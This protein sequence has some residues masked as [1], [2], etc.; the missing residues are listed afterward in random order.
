MLTVTDEESGNKFLRINV[1]GFEG[2][3]T[4]LNGVLRVTDD[5][6]KLG[7]AG[8]T[9]DAV[10]FELSFKKVKDVALCAGDLK[11]QSSGS[12]GGTGQVTAMA[13]DNLGNVKLSG[14]TVIIANIN[15]DEF[16]TV[17]IVANFAK[18]TI[19]AYAADGTVLDSITPNA[20]SGFAS[21]AE[22]QRASNGLKHHILFM[23]YWNKNVAVTDEQ[24]GALTLAPASIYVDNIKIVDGDV[25]G[26]DEVEDE[27]IEEENVKF[28]EISGEAYPTLDVQWPGTDANNE[29]GQVNFQTIGEGTGYKTVTLE[30]GEKYI[31]WNKGTRNTQLIW[32]ASNFAAE[33]NNNKV[34]TYQFSFAKN[35]EAA[36]TNLAARLRTFNVG[37]SRQDLVLYTLDNAGNVKLGAAADAPTICTLGTD[38]TTFGIVLDFETGT[39]YA[40]DAD[41][42]LVAEA[43]IPLPAGYNTA[44]ELYSAIDQGFGFYAGESATASSL[45]IKSITGTTGNL[46]ATAE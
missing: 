45:L 17:R 26:K 43:A 44:V 14:S 39:L 24:T 5:S 41:G 20:P 31:E 40:Y 1:D 15:E 6:K 7:I 4:G 9:E 11:L 12:A 27:V 18:G 33:T 21:L 28:F 2:S 16:V 34:L 22:W 19:T 35:G 8:F 32:T 36:I 29:I 3:A 46:Y 13:F 10:T 42:A 38:F 23:N 30:G 25:Y 37:G